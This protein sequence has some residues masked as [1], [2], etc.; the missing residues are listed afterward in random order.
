MFIFS[1]FAGISFAF[2]GSLEGG[3]G[4]FIV[5]VGPSVTGF[6]VL[7][8]SAVSAIGTTIAVTT[9]PTTKRPRRT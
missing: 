3:V 7:V 8:S 5:A 2:S 4:P 6:V 1:Q 9:T